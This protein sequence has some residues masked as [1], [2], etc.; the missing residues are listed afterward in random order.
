MG[1]RRDDPA[2]LARVLDHASA[3]IFVVD[4]DLIIRWVNEPAAELFGYRVDQLIGTPALDYVDTDWNPLAF[5]SIATAMGAEGSRLPMLFRVIR[6][7]G[8]KVVVELIA[9]SQ[10]D[11][12][13][14]QGMVVHARRA[15]ERML[16]DQ[17]LEAMAASEPLDQT[18]RLLVQIAESETLDGAAAVLHDRRGRRFAGVVAS[19]CLVEPLRGPGVGSSVD[20]EWE[21]VLAAG[22]EQVHPV[23]G[24]PPAIAGAA[25]AA[26]FR[27]CWVWSADASEG[28]EPPAWVVV[29][30]R[31]DHTDTDQTRRM[32]VAR[33]A[34]LAGLVVDRVRA[35]EATVWA[36]THDSLTGLANRARF[37]AD[38]EEAL[39]SAGGSALTAVLFLDVD[40]FKPVND[41]L[42]HLAGDQLLVALGHR[43]QD[44]VRDDDLVAR[45]GGDEFAVLC[46]S[47]ASVTDLEAMAGR[48]VG[49]MSERMRLDTGSVQVGVSVGIAVSRP[50]QPIGADELVEAADAAMYQVKSS[51]KDGWSL[52]TVPVARRPRPG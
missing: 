42:G 32:A 3:V 28:G 11:D 49:R 40:G 15:D 17:A 45:L 18:L 37:Y 8:E 27:T 7:D 14:V 30:R 5:D 2:L 51:G 12:P 9:D 33:L 23:S 41:A 24:L 36:A 34:R 52:V 20:E 29:W 22:T 16:L 4:A 38:L 48:V 26:G 50:G 35:E 10:Y 39:A 46:R 19:D 25:E 21:A 47:V 6:G 13:V 43:L 1:G 31:E 44:G